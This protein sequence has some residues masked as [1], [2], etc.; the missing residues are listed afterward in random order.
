MLEGAP[1]KPPALFGECSGKRH[2]EIFEGDSTAAGEREECQVT[3]AP[4]KPPGERRRQ[5]AD[6]AD[7]SLQ[8]DTDR[9]RRSFRISTPIGITESTITIPTTQ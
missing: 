9:R 2:L 6:A 5:S 8:R 4:A 1:T 7:G 3:E